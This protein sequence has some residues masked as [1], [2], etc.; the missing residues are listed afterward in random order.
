MV[1][2]KTVLMGAFVFVFFV[3]GTLLINVITGTQLSGG[4]VLAAIISGV[5]FTVHY[6][7][8]MYIW[9]KRQAP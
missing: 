9:A 1:N 5:I 7:I 3:L 8:G 4:T 2:R 6:S